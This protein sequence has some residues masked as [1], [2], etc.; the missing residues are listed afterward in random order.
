MTTFRDQNRA[1]DAPA[2]FDQ[3]AIAAGTSVDQTGTTLVGELPPDP[4]ALSAM[5]AEYGI[6]ILGPPPAA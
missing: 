2:G 5:A 1:V 4:A 3:F 6:E